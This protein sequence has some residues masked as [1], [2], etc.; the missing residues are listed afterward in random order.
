MIDCTVAAMAARGVDCLGGVTDCL[1]VNADV[2]AD[3]LIG[4]AAT[5]LRGLS[6]RA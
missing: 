1:G 4:V 6:D 2:D 5:T 3:G